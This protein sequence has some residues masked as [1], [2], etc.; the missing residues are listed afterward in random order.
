[1]ATPD[2]TQT[3]RTV[4]LDAATVEQLGAGISAR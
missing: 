2:A 3:L 4:L 1:M